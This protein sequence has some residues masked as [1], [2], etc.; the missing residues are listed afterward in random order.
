[1]R[2]W[3]T[4]HRFKDF[5]SVVIVDPVMTEEATKSSDKGHLQNAVKKDLYSIVDSTM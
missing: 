3:R 2:E 1:M 4:P 5:G